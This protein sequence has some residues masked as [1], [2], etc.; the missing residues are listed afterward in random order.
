MVKLFGEENKKSRLIAKEI[1]KKFWQYINKKK[2]NR[3]PTWD[4]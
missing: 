1:L 4:I 3:K 2:L